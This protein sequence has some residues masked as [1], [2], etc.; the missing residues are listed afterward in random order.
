MFRIDKGLRLLFDQFS[1]LTDN[2]IL[3]IKN[4]YLAISFLFVIMEVISIYQML[5][6]GSEYWFLFGFV[7]HILLIITLMSSEYKE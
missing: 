4:N 5:T 6:L 2:L 1:S 3:K 7:T